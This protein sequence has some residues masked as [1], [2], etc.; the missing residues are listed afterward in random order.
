M[1]NIFIFWKINFFKDVENADAVQK[2]LVRQ[3]TSS[4]DIFVLSN[5]STKAVKSRS[6]PLI[7]NS[8]LKKQESR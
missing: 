2:Y 8:N 7:R 4:L 3:K 1:L 6:K 5:T